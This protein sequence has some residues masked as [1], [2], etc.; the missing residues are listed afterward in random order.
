[1]QPVYGGSCTVRFDHDQNEALVPFTLP[2]ERIEARAVSPASRREPASGELIRVLQTSPERIKPR[3]RHFG[4][5][6]GCDYQH[7]TQAAQLALKQQVLLD[8]LSPAAKGVSLQVHSGEPW[9][10]RNRARFRVVGDQIGYN[11]RNS[12]SFLPVTECPIASPLLWRAIEAAREIYKAGLVLWPDTLTEIELFTNTQETALQASLRLGSSLSSMDRDAPAVFRKFCEQWQKRLPEIAGAGLS[13]IAEPL[14]GD[15][16][17]VS[18]ARSI[19]VARW[20]EQALSYQ[21]GNRLHQVTRNAFFQVNRFLTETM[22][23][24]VCGD[25]T[26]KRAY[27]LF[28]GAGLFSL[29]LTERFQE[30]TAVE[31]GQPAA[32]DLARALQASPGKHRAEHQTV[33]A[34]LQ[35]QAGRPVPELIVMDPPR[36][37]LGDAVTRELCRLAAPEMVY[38]SCDPITFARDT[39]VL[40]QS[41]YTLH[42][43]HLLDLFPQT[44]HME[45]IAVFHR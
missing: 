17:R 40:L 41:G 15:S 3:C 16:K 23:E 14:P 4:V 11:R 6:G 39:K 13:V 22:V 29:P 33:L 19:E 28:A 30:V 20:G 27:D 7:A 31:I 43:L 32:D 9:H 5:C 42:R 24:L 38:V 44:F 26:G 36:A 21:V 18:A 45:T 35:D 8:A 37:G 1:M 12:N 34:F 2:G 25:R 10:Y